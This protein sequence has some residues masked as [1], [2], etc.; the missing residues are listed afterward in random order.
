MSPYKSIYACMKFSNIDIMKIILPPHNSFLLTVS[1]NVSAS[2]ESVY[3]GNSA[4][5]KTTQ[6]F[7]ISSSICYKSQQFVSNSLALRMGCWLRIDDIIPAS[8]F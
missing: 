6:F 2:T 3:G 7:F 4:V 1:D 5:V 8:V